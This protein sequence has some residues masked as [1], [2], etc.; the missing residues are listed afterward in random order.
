MESAYMDRLSA[1]RDQWVSLFDTVFEAGREVEKQA[2]LALVAD[3]RSLLE[4]VQTIARNPPPPSE[5]Q[6]MAPQRADATK[7][8]SY[9][10]KRARPGFVTEAVR[11]L[12]NIATAPVG[13]LVIVRMAEGENII[14][15]ASSVRMALQTL[16]ERGEARQ[17]KHGDWE[18]V[19]KVADPDD[20]SGDETLLHVPQG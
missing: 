2:T 9:P 17:V 13:P 11:R 20:G 6:Q 5:P 1:L 15:N 19:R 3:M 4:R 12:L 7:S 18:A 10:A 8:I 16:R 14:L